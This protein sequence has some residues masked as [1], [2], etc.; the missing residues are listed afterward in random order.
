MQSKNKKTALSIALILII[1]MGAS[2]ILVPNTTAHTPK[3]NIPTY[4]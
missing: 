3:W 2:T 4:A 1:S